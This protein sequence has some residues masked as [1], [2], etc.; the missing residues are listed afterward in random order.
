[1]VYVHVAYVLFETAVLVFLSRMIRREA[2]ETASI[3]ALGE[4]VANGG[5]IDLGLAAE[6]ALGASSRGLVKFLAAIQ[7]AVSSAAS[8][9]EGVSGVSHSI[10]GTATRLVRSARQ[11]SITSVS[12]LE[13]VERMAAATGDIASNCIEV[14][15]VTRSSAI[16]IELGRD[17]MGRSVQLI[18][19]L[20]A[21]VADVSH[22]I[23]SLHT[24]SVRIEGLIEII[25]DIADQTRLLALNASIEAAR[26]GQFG[27]GFGVVAQEVRDLSERTHRSL[28]QAQILVSEVKSQTDLVLK[29]ANLCREQAVRGGL[30]VE[31]ANRNLEGV[32]NELPVIADRADNVIAIASRHSS[33]AAE[34]SLHMR[35]IGE[36]IAQSSADLDSID[37]FSHSLRAMSG[38][39]CL[40]VDAF[41]IHPAA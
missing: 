33:L 29:S 9:A 37:S 22:E 17:S 12:V 4:R 39:L 14:A 21:Q 41:N 30:Q 6:Q 20:A 19:A 38:D 32:L 35:T 7:K 8:I 5:D 2:L 18:D 26:A 40:G 13:A 25:A 24:G 3:A 10:T 11:Q 16:V 23:E 34:V 36:S 1:M 27:R 15:R 31:E 28:H